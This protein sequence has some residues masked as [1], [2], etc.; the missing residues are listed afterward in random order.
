MPLF[1][2]HF[3]VCLFVEPRYEDVYTKVESLEGSQQ[4][5]CNKIGEVK[6]KTEEIE[7]SV[8]QWFPKYEAA[9]RVLNEVENRLTKLEACGRDD[10]KRVLDKDSFVSLYKDLLSLRNPDEQ[11]R[12]SALQCRRTRSSL[13]TREKFPFLILESRIEHVATATYTN[14]RSALTNNITWF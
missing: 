6:D 12:W 11:S 9:A 5:L 7:K 4:G 2:S 10:E 3:V 1:F 13:D 14:L 8:A